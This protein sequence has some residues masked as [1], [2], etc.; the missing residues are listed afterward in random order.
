MFD[1]IKPEKLNYGDTIGIIAPSIAMK[2][3]YIQNSVKQLSALGFKVKLSAHIFSNA[4]GYAGSV[5]ERAEDF[6]SM[7]SDESVKMI[8]FGGGEVCNE[9][10]PYIDYENICRH[11]KIICSYSDSTTLLNAINCKSGLVTFY[12]A[13]VR[14]FENLTEYNFHSFEKRFMTAETRYDKSAPWKTIRAGECEGVLVGGYLVNYAALYGL[15]YYPEIP[16]DSCILFIED[17]EMFSSPAVVSKWF[18]NLEHR[19]VFKKVSGLIF[20]HYSEND[21]P[22]IDGILY[23]IGEKYDIP[24]VRCEDFGH[25]TNNSILPIGIPASLDTEKDSFELLESG[26][27]I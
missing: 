17:H 24:V 25:G 9:I 19:N 16:Y 18:A 27:C 26:V 15:E 2:P 12:G 8:L 21:A 14:T 6:N 10:L 5:E 20:G 3:E 22:L 4:N 7:I 23:R 11:P 1:L 13:S